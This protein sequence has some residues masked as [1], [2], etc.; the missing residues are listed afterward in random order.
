MKRRRDWSVIILMTVVLAGIAA[1]VV[2]LMVTE[3]RRSRAVVRAKAPKAMGFYEALAAQRNEGGLAASADEP[4]SPTPSKASQA[5]RAKPDSENATALSTLANFERLLKWRDEALANSDTWDQLLRDVLKLPPDE[6][7]DAQ[8]QLLLDFVAEHSDLIAEIRRLAEMGGPVY[9]LDFSVPMYALEL[10]H[11][12]KLRDCGRLLRA[13]A[14]AQALQGGHREAVE[15]IVAGLKLSDALEGEPLL[16]SQLVRYAMK[17]VAAT[18]ITDAFDWGELS[19]D[20]ARDLLHQL[21]QGR[22]RRALGDALGGEQMMGLGVFSAVLE[23][24]GTVEHL[25]EFRGL[26][27]P[28]RVG[29]WLYSTSVAR[30]W[31]NM[32]EQLYMESTER[33]R[34]AA[35]LPYYEA[36]PLLDALEQEL[37]DIPFTRVFSSRMLPAITRIQ[38]A[39]AQNEAIAD[40][41]R[42]GIALELYYQERGSYPEQLDAVASYLGGSVPADTLTG[43]PFHYTPQGDTFL[44][45]SVGRNLTDEGG[46]YDMRDGDI[47]WRGRAE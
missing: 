9:P 10:P 28:E 30:P 36:K 27:D 33:M 29:L 46:K 32:D 5:S 34:E 22:D 44:L 12:A 21:N 35:L 11:L 24:P 47:V 3:A 26:S 15:D 4:A 23:G 2:L 41:A 31:L 43:R 39:R 38:Q 8:R 20:L 18:A 7:T 16:I 19:P 45:Y 14:I 37:E 42:V 40:V 13:D 6:W 1:F 17:G 25:G